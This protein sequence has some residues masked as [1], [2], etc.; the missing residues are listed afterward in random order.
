L[1]EGSGRRYDIV[2][3]TDLASQGTGTITSRTGKN[4]EAAEFDST[5]AQHLTHKS[6]GLEGFRAGAGFI[7][8]GWINI[9]VQQTQIVFE[10]TVQSEPASTVLVLVNPV[11][12]ISFQVRRAD[13]VAV[14]T[15]NSANQSTGSF[16]HYVGIADNNQL[17]LYVDNVEIGP[18]SIVGFDNL[19]PT[20]VTLSGNEVGGSPFEGAIDEVA[21]WTGISFADDAER[22]AFVNALFNGGAGRFYKGSQTNESSSQ[23]TSSSE[24]SSS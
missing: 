14:S 24:S 21:V 22:Q 18:A 2:G 5:K 11:G 17:F 13:L 1:G 20:H 3:G 23:H 7:V 10:S 16:I 8:S 4:G 6:P 9:D 19:P 15:V 12:K